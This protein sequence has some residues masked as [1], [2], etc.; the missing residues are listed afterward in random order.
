[1]RALRLMSSEPDP[2]LVEV[3]EREPGPGEVVIRVGGAGTCHADLQAVGDFEPGQL[4]FELPVT[5]GHENA[6]WVESLG[7][8]VTGLEVGQPVAV[9]GPWECGSCPRSWLGMETRTRTSERP[10]SRWAEGAS[11]PTA[12]WLSSCSSPPPASSCLPARSRK[13]PRCSPTPA[14]RCRSPPHARS[15]S[16]H[17]RRRRSSSASGLRPMTLQSLEAVPALR[18]VAIDRPR[19][20]STR[21]PSGAPMSPSTPS[22][23]TRGPSSGRRPPGCPVTSPSI[24][25]ADGTLPVPFCSVPYEVSPGP[26]TAAAVWS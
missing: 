18:V 8:V 11:A 19:T 20:R 16:S 7:E 14:S 15:H 1:M 9:S 4:R 5:L 12:A 21:A 13:A 22:A 6:G 24:G 26:P 23:P 17:R 3:D 2:V 10:P 25:L